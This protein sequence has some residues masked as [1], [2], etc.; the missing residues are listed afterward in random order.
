MAHRCGYPAALFSG[1]GGLPYP[2]P[3]RRVAVECLA[4]RRP[5]QNRARIS[6][7]RVGKEPRQHE[8]AQ[9]GRRQPQLVEA[10]DDVV[11]GGDREETGDRFTGDD[12]VAVGFL[13]VQIPWRAAQVLIDEPGRWRALAEVPAGVDLW[14]DEA[15]RDSLTADDSTAAAL[16]R[17]LCALE[18]V[19]WV[20]AGKLL[21]RK[22]PQLLPVYDSVVKV[23]LQP[24]SDRWW[25]PLRASLRNHPAVVENL[26]ALHEAAGLPAQVSLLRTLDVVVWMAAW[27]RGGRKRQAA[28]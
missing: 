15:E 1:T 10:L 21:A 22:R 23:T 9:T 19:G 8:A 28:N 16:W 26:M 3:D 12:I 6:C 4:S 7:R 25:E 20:T 24:D 18:G 17:D 14:S 5:E 27:G 11:G 13:S 2:V